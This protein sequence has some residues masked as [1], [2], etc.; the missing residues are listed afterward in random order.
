MGDPVYS[1]ELVQ[2]Y[3]DLKKGTKVGLE[4]TNE[5]EGT[6]VI[7]VPNDVT[8]EVDHEVVPA[9]VVESSYTLMLQARYAQNR[10]EAEGKVPKIQEILVALGLVP[11]EVDFSWEQRLGGIWGT[12]DT[13][14]YE[15]HL[16]L[17]G[18]RLSVHGTY[19]ENGRCLPYQSTRPSISIDFSRPVATIVKDINRRFI[20]AYN[21]LFEKSRLRYEANN[22]YGARRKAAVQQV[23]EA[24]G[25]K[26]TVSGKDDTVVHINHGGCYID[27]NMGD[28]EATISGRLPIS[29][30]KILMT[31]I[32]GQ[33]SK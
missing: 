25:S 23:L 26:A 6:H 13:P 30:A 17:R 28:T 10:V 8:G 7:A 1:F 24:G 9:S 4:S 33:P 2:D 12:N 21:E 11:G 15:I 27:F 29:I 3:G 32:A 20:P 14:G 19:H 18:T 16:S 22:A 31:M 5:A